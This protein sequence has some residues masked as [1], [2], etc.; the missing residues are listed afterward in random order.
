MG[1]GDEILVVRRDK[2][3]SKGDFQGFLS[4]EE[5]DYMSAILDNHEFVKRTLELERNREYQQPITYVWI[6][7]PREK[8]VFAYRRR[9]GHT[10]QR[11]KDK[12]TCGVGGH[13]DKA[14]E[15]G[16]SNPVLTAMTRELREEVLMKNYPEPRIVGYLN[17]DGD[18]EDVHFGVMG[19][20]E[21]EGE[22]SGNG[23]FT[24]GRFYGIEELDKE[25]EDPNNDV[26]RWTKVSWPF[27]KDYLSKL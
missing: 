26:E 27:V 2:L 23:E 5:G 4:V 21:T 1:M 17:L 9:S 24:E 19:I 16:L 18:V 12:L 22:V 6:V 7:N 8:K 14:T 3:F 11:L 20:V 25:F 13:I 15:E 10:E